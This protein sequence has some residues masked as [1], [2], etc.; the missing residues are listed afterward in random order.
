MSKTIKKLFGNFF[1]WMAQKHYDAHCW[2]ELKH[3]MRGKPPEIKLRMI[4]KFQK[5]HPNF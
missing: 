1:T 5:E 2:Y 4:D 3:D